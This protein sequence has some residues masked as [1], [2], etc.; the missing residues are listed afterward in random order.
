MNGGLLHADWFLAL[1]DYE[2]ECQKKG[3]HVEDDAIR[4]LDELA[5]NGNPNAL[6]LLTDIGLQVGDLVACWAG[7]IHYER[8]EYEL[9]LKCYQVGEYPRCRKSIPLLCGSG[10]L[11]QYGANV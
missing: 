3:E 10:K 9:A 6:V 11:L 5:K 2:V 1:L 8:Q 4:L 7:D